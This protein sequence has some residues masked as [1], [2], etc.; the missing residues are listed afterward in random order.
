MTFLNVLRALFLLLS[1]SAA[2]SAFAPPT[3]LVFGPAVGINAHGKHVVLLSGDEEYRSEEALPMLAK[4]L[5]QRHGFKTTVLFALDADGTINPNNG[6]SLPDS[7]ALDTADVIIMALR[8]RAWPD[9]AMKRFEAAYKRGVPLIA[10][11]TSARAF[12]FPAGT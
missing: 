12:D 7:A 9:D 11:R 10:L 2:L 8:F 4:I 3:T 5:S 6:K 1:G